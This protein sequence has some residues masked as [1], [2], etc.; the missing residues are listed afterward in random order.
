MFIFLQL[1]RARQSLR[2]LDMAFCALKI[3]RARRHD[4]YRSSQTTSHLSSLV[5][6]HYSP[7]VFLVLIHGIYSIGQMVC[8][9]ELLRSFIDVHLLCPPSFKV[10]STAFHF[11]ADY[12]FTAH[13]NDYRMCHQHLGIR[14]SS[15]IG[16][17]FL[18]NLIDKHQTLNRHVCKLLH[19]LRTLLPSHL[20][21]K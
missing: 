10:Q 3:T 12:G 13:S 14:F 8:R 15:A 5:S 19:T 2:F 16:L 1:H 7:H 9:H 11:N 18:P 21:V 20:F 17:T 6:S 4:L